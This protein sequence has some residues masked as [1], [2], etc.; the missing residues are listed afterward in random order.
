[1]RKYFLF[2]L[3]LISSQTFSQSDSIVSKKKIALK[4]NP[5]ALID[6]NAFL[7]AELRLFDHLNWEIDAGYLFFLPQWNVFG[8]Y[9]Y[10]LDFGKPNF[11]IKTEL[12]YFFP[13]TN[14]MGWYAAP[15][16]FYRQTNY[17]TQHKICNSWEIDSSTFLITGDEYDL[18][19]TCIEEIN[20]YKVIRQVI[21][22][23]SKWGYQKVWNNK[24]LLDFYFGFGLKI[25]SRKIIGKKEGLPDPLSYLYND[26]G[27]EGFFFLDALIIGIENEGV[28]PNIPLGIRIGILF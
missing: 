18:R 5:T 20:Q 6:N 22:I 2:F 21:G 3:V 28:I 9:G 25:I 17:T 16:F 12:R 14:F 27:P 11:N 19:S 15:Q 10:N 4:F 26:E 8:N 13:K 24:F 23:S 1:M 7:S